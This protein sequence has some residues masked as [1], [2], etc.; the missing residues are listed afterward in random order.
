MS[1]VQLGLAVS[2]GLSEQLG[3]TGVAWLRLVWAGLILLVVARPWRAT[4]TRKAFWTCVALG[5]ATAGM[6]VFFMCAVMLI[7][8]GTASALEF[9]GPL[10]VA[11]ARGTGRSRLWAIVAAAGVIALTE[12]WHG[13]ADPIGILFALGA[14][15]CWGVYILL[16]QRAGD[17]VEGL[18]A[19]AVSIP[20]AAA[21]ASFTITP[22]LFA[23]LDLTVLLAGLGLALLLPL[24]PFILEL[25]SLR[26]LNTATFG[27]LMSL[28]PAFALVI[29]AAI[30]HQIPTPLAVVGIALVIT[31]G[32]G[33]TRTGARS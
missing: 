25:L 14:A 1:C 13:R 6:T 5:A 19:L 17:S 29:G 8:L 3:P 10:G 33:A 16:T 12:P 27:T 28:E 15:A 18:N 23:K 32:I 21:V 30:L 20:T 31:A 7:P 11:V 2:V 26:R 4:F 9:L 22:A 24:V